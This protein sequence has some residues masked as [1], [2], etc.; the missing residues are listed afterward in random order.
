MGKV[1]ADDPAKLTD[2]KLLSF[3]V[4]STLIDEKA[5]MFAG[6]QPLL[7]RLPKPN[8]YIND[9][10]FTLEKFQKFERELQT[11]RP[12]LR[13]NELLPLA[14]ISFA[15][16]LS[17]PSPSASEAA[18]FGSLIGSWSAF[19]DTVP[20]L[21]ALKKHYKLVILSNIDNDSIK[22]TVEG[23]LSGVDFD[24]ILTA[25]DIGSYK[26]DLRNFKYLLEKVKELGVEKGEVLHTAQALVHDHAPAKIM[27]MHS[28]WIDREEQEDLLKELGDKVSFTWKYKT[29][30]EMAEAVEKEFGND[31]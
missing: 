12:T 4:Y 23:P 28:A 14:Y 22:R 21:Q 17:L 3:D 11:T 6:L 29:M 26:P 8:P 25:Q 2:F 16:S 7:T 5:G 27:E 9:L 20:A 15:E 13:F 19:P 1:R 31:S 10:K 18:H 30:G 24:L